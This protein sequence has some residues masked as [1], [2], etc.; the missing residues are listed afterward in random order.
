MLMFHAC[1]RARLSEMLAAN[2]AESPRSSLDFT[3]ASLSGRLT[4]MG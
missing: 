1:D 3:H 2:A 4:D